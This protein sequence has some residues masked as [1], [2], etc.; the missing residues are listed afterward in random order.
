MRL[1]RALAYVIL[2]Y[3]LAAVPVLS[4]CNDDDS[5]SDAPGI[6]GF[7]FYVASDMRGFSHAEY[8][9]SQYFR[10][11]CEA[12]D[13][14]GGGA[15]MVVSGDLDPPAWTNDAIAD[16]LGPDYKWYPVIGNHD[17]EDPADMQWLR[18]WGSAH[19]V[20]FVRTGPANG[21]ET[22]YSFDYGNAHIVVINEFYD[23]TSDV[24]AD[25]DVTDALYEWVELDLQQNGQ[26][27]VFVFGHEPFFSIPDVDNGR[28]R[29][30]NGCL[31]KHPENSSRFRS[32]LRDYGVKAYICGHT[33]NC[34]FTKIDG[35]WQIDA[36]HAQGIGDPGAKSTFLEVSVYQH[37]AFVDI[38]RDDGQGGPYSLEYT[39]ELD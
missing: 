17:A 6:E 37:D 12:I 29:H 27:M 7:S 28:V 34:S 10:G 1:K 19:A 2:Y 20:S 33:H 3:T 8:S 5:H 11:A 25:G 36:G 4:G 26:P 32:L 30:L 23:G 13:A 24:G 9:S 39:I 21:T 22:T 14:L 38:Y 31:D 35:V 18:E 16:V 15:F